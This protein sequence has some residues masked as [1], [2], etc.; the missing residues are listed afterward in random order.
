MV[1]ARKAQTAAPAAPPPSQPSQLVEVYT[2]ERC[3]LIKQVYGTRTV[4]VQ[5]VLHAPHT[6]DHIYMFTPTF[7]GCC[8]IRKA[9]QVF[10]TV[11]N[12]ICVSCRH[13]NVCM[14]TDVRRGSGC[15]RP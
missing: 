13:G 1:D 3:C 15:L 9:N 5:I 8:R 2:N 10:N 12:V 11:S 14:E 4:R 7:Q 6:C